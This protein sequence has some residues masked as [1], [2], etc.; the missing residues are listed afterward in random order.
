MDMDNDV[1]TGSLLPLGNEKRGTDVILTIKFGILWVY[2]FHF[3]DLQLS[4]CASI[5]AIF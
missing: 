2:R 1:S 3:A 4:F 5:C